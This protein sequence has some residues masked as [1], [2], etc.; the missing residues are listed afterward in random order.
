M[1]D[2]FYAML[3]SRSPVAVVILSVA[4]M[5]FGGFAMTRLTKRARLPNVTAYILTGILLGPSVLNII[6]AGLIDG[7]EFLS[8]VALAF[9][10]FGVGRFFKVSHLKRSGLRV[11]VIT[12]LEA[13][14]ASLLVFIVTFFILGLEPSFAIVLSV[15]ASCTAPA[16]TMM[17]IRQTG[18][19]GDF[20]DTLLLV[21]ALDNVLSLVAYS[22]A[23]T[24]ATSNGFSLVTVALPILRNLLAVVIG[25]VFG[26]LLKL[27]I[28]SK[29]SDDNRLIIVIGVLFL[30]CGICAILDVSPLLGCMMLGAVYINLADDE[31]LFMQ[32]N[33]FNPPVLLLFFVRSGLSFNLNALTQGGGQIGSSPLWLISICYFAVRI[34]GKYAGAWLGC[35]SVK[36]PKEVRNNLGLALIPQAGVAIGLAAMGARQLGGETGAALETV[37][38]ASSILYEIVG[39]PLAKLSLYLSHSYSDKLEEL[40]PVEEPE[41]AQKNDVEILIARIQKIQSELPPH[42]VSISEEERAFDEAAQQYESIS[43]NRRGLMRRN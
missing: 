6:P 11:I 12:A 9:I 19:K 15:L 29:R 23:I 25:G 10:S 30:F 26:L 39:P 7:T 16:S 43:P 24:A 34:I 21:V 35:F 38:L 42:G 1:L 4:L 31:K 18:A 13:L 5:L 14:L 20:V 41:G 40:A 22:V 32:L 28:V 33:Y 8:D 36:K 27:L 2:S 3:E 17:T 37:I